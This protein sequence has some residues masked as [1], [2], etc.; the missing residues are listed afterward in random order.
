[1]PQPIACPPYLKLGGTT[2]IAALKRPCGYCGRLVL[3][4]SRKAR[5]PS[6]NLLCWGCFR[7]RQDEAR[8][9]RAAPARPRFNASASVPPW[10]ASTG[11]IERKVVMP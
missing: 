10:S 1:M 8:Q 9:R 11:R 5:D 4:Q 7:V 6:A 3:A 2:E